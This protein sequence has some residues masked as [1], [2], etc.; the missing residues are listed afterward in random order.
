LAL[1]AV[2]SALDGVFGTGQSRHVAAW[3]C[4]K[5]TDH[6]EEVEDDGTIVQRERERFANE[7]TLVY[8]SGETIVL[9]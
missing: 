1:L 9:R 3:R 7:L 6:S 2:S 4:V 5:L 8:T